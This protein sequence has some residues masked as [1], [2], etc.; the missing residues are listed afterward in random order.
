MRHVRH[1]KLHTF[2]NEDLQNH[3]NTSVQ[4]SRTSK[5]IDLWCAHAPNGK[6]EG[7]HTFKDEDLNSCTNV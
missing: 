1:A 5:L 7:V 2:K 6:P 3:K 4:K